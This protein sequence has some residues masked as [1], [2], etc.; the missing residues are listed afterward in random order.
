MDE[1]TSASPDITL[2]RA[3]QTSIACPSQW[4]AWDADGNYYY[5]RYRHGCGEMRRYKSEN[6]TDAP[7]RENPDDGQPGWAIRGNT[8]Y[9]ATVA[10]FDYGDPLDGV[11]DLADFAEL[12]GIKLAPG[13]M[14][15]GF[16]D[17]VRDKLILDGTF[18]PSILEE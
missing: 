11:I 3:V 8:D 13:I 10:L 15:S 12:A 9:I 16:G 6:W 5:L 2:V 7:W 17:H 18:P 14:Y 4:D 1:S